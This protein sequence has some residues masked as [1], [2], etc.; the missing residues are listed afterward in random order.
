[1]ISCISAAPGARAARQ[2]GSVPASFKVG[3][4]TVNEELTICSYFVLDIKEAQ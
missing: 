2:A 4:S 3:M 1:M